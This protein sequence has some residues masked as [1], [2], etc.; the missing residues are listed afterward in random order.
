MHLFTICLIIESFCFQTAV[1]LN[2]ELMR[3]SQRMNFPANAFSS[4]AYDAIWSIALTLHKS[5]AVFKAHNKSLSNVT[6]GDR[7]ITNVFKRVLRNLTFIGM[8]VSWYTDN[9]QR[10]GILWVV[11][12]EFKVATNSFQHLDSDGSL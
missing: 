6:Y 5:S 8:S 10:D 11:L 9:L 1:E 7:E 4:F 3:K 12:A 2:K